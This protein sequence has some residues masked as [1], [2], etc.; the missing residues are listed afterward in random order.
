MSNIKNNPTI[1][2]MEI[3]NVRRAA[4]EH[5]AKWAGAF[6]MEAK[7]EGIDLEPIMRRA[8]YNIG[9]QSGKEELEKLGGKVSAGSYGRYF[10]T[11]SLHETFEKAIEQDGEDDFV[12]SLN[13]CPLVHAWQ[14]M[15]LDDETCHLLCDIAMDGDRG[16]AEGLGLDFELESTMSAGCKNCRLH[17]RSKK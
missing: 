6:Y 3:V 4:I 7:K 14:K 17:Y 1:T 2:D 11:K 8:I 10:C 16:I 5:R 13:Y 12:C 15:G 9:L